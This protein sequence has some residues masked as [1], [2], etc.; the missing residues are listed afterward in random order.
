MSMNQ[1]QYQAGYILD[2]INEMLKDY[3]KEKEVKGL[4][5]HL[6]CFDIET[7]CNIFSN[8]GNP[9]VSVIHNLISRG[10]GAVKSMLL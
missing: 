9:F 7:D 10:G 3:C 8:S 5:K 6:S 4:L 2:S 1:T